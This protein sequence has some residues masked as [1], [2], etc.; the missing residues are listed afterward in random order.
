MEGVELQLVQSQ[1]SKLEWKGRDYFIAVDDESNV[2]SVGMVVAPTF[3]TTNVPNGFW[4]TN[5]VNGSTILFVLLG[6]VAATLGE[7]IGLVEPAQD[8]WHI[9]I[10]N[11]VFARPI[12]VVL[13]V[14]LQ[15]LEAMSFRA[16]ASIAQATRGDEIIG[17]CFS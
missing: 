7:R 5:F 9:S 12:R 1:A 17:S 14:A 16:T 6:P 11:A 8:L 3:A 13:Q 4:K 10:E 15:M 2:A